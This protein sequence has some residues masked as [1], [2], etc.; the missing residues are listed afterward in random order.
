M[1]PAQHFNQAVFN[2]LKSGI[3]ALGD[4]PNQARRTVRE[5]QLRHAIVALTAVEGF[6]ESQ[7][8]VLLLQV[9]R[10]RLG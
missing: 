6:S 2:R 10:G 1:H 9:D 5:T 4:E 7:S 3:R 8:L